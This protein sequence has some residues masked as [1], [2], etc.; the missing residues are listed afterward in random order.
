MKS[1]NWKRNGEN[2]KLQ[3][4]TEYLLGLTPVQFNKN[5]K[6]NKNNKSNGT[7]NANFKSAD[8]KI[9]AQDK[10][11]AGNDS[12]KIKNEKNSEN[13]KDGQNYN[14][15]NQNGEDNPIEQAEENV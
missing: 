5:D 15:N 2:S 14:E 10:N 9:I 7:Q 8:G 12:S 1:K 6:N 13:S 11:Q 3:T 4:L